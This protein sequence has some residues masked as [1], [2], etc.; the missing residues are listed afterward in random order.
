MWLWGKYRGRWG[1]YLYYFMSFLDMGGILFL[2][3]VSLHPED[4]FN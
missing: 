3:D 4:G 2:D 1:K